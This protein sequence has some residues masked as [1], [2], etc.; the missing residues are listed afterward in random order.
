MTAQ[1]NMRSLEHCFPSSEMWTAVIFFQIYVGLQILVSVTLYILPHLQLSLFSFCISFSGYTV[2]GKY[3]CCF[4]VS[5]VQHYLVM[6]KRT[7]SFDGDCY[8]P[9]SFTNP[10]C[11]PPVISCIVMSCIINNC[12]CSSWVTIK[13]AEF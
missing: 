11:V 6:D 1:N 13:C 10:R 2:C 12:K 5:L 8:I 7:W 4:A 3:F 9:Q